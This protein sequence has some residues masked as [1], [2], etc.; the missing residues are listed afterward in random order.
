MWC[1]ADT[2]K[3]EKIKTHGNVP[4]PRSG[5]QLVQVSLTPR[6]SVATAS[7]H[8]PDAPQLDETRILL[9]GGLDDNDSGDHMFFDDIYLFDASSQ[10]S[11]PP[12]PPPPI[13]LLL[14][15]CVCVCDSDT[16]EWTQPRVSG[17]KPRGRGGHS[18]VQTGPGRFVCFGGNTEL[19]VSDDCFRLVVDL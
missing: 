16:R 9:H 10:P 7:T 14:A 11:S 19:G 5:A 13:D 18:F 6:C 4:P 3:W 12:P 1:N 17:H 2:W 8:K 15:V